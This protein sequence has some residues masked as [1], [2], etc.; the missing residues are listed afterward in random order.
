MRY[1]EGR[2]AY[3]IALS[4]GVYNKIKAAITENFMVSPEVEKE[5]EEVKAA[6]K[7]GHVLPLAE[8]TAKRKKYKRDMLEG[9]YGYNPFDNYI[10]SE[11]VE[12]MKSKYPDRF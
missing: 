4:D 12:R 5:I 1:V 3:N 7:A 2:K 8:L 6:I 9:D 10:S 11:K